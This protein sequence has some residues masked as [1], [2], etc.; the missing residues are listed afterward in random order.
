V[1]YILQVS[2]VTPAAIDLFFPNI[3]S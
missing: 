3:C 2:N 1:T